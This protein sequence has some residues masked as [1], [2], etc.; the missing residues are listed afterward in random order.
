MQ[1]GRNVLST[2][3]TVNRG[4]GRGF[5][6]KIGNTGNSS[7]ARLDR[8]NGRG[9]RKDDYDTDGGNRSYGTTETYYNSN[10]NRKTDNDDDSNGNDDGRKSTPPFENKSPVNYWKTDYD[11]ETVGYGGDK[12]PEEAARMPVT[13]IPPDIQQLSM[14]DIITGGN[15][16]ADYDKIEVRCSGSDVPKPLDSFRD[17]GFDDDFY[18]SISALY[19]KP[20]PIQKYAIPCIITGRDIMAC[21]QTGSG[22]TVSIIIIV[23]I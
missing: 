2:G 16:F 3:R 13:Y 10:S 9:Y 22:K 20:T 14:D 21:S 18:R 11:N 12:N 23:P 1:D 5:V 6:S 19:K 17:A 4:R 8:E 7:A 15:A